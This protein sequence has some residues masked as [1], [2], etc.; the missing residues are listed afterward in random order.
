MRTHTRARAA[1]KPPQIKG[2]QFGV[3]P[4]KDTSGGVGYFSK[5]TYTEGEPFKD[6]T[7]WRAA[8]PRGGLFYLY[9]WYIL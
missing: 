1:P 4:P 2:K 7:G 6:K 5:M 9:I 3:V 8:V